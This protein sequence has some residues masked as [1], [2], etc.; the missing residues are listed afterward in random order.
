MKRI[1]HLAATL[2]ATLLLTG[3]TRLTGMLA[4]PAPTPLE[5]LTLERFQANAPTIRTQGTPEPDRSQALKPI[6]GIVLPEVEPLTLEGTVLMTGKHSLFPLTAVLYREFIN[7]GFQGE[8]RLEE[9]ST[10]MGIELFCAGPTYDVVA[11]IRPMIQAELE[12]CL[13]NGRSPIVLQVGV[14]AL[15]NVANPSNDF[16][17]NIGSV[18][19]FALLLTARRW[20]DVNPNWPDEP[21]RRYLPLPGSDVANLVVDIGLFDNERL[22]VTSPNA[23][24]SD[25]PTEL[26]QNIQDDPFAFGVLD[27]DVYAANVDRLKIV[28]ILG[29]RPE[30]AMIDS[31]A[32]VAVYPLLLYV[33]ANTIQRRPQV[34]G[35]LMFYLNQ[36]N[37]DLPGVDEFMIS[38]MLL[39]HSKINLLVALDNQVF[40][41]ELAE[42]PTPPA[43]TTVA[44]TATPTP[45]P[46]RATSTPTATASPKSS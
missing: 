14:G 32:Y 10:T 24:F 13:Q 9:A 4:P 38:P 12:R 23:V 17:Q 35:F 29:A 2:L 31:G 33:D 19:E 1:A 27:Y 22:L 7:Q 30:Q 16:L 21:I 46:P 37:R 45:T 43:V 18:D 41:Q 40:L 5:D 15:V 25:D 36:V 44:T 20:S 28:T 11:A 34:G 26:L 39:D 42:R 3:C 8:V 6:V